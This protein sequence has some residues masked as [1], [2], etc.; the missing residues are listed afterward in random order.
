MIKRLLGSIKEYKK[1]S[2]LTPIFIII[3][4]AMEVLIP[5]LINWFGGCLQNGDGKGMLI[6]GLLMVLS[7][8]I[9]LM[10]GM[11]AG[12]TCAKAAT[13]FSKN[14]LYDCLFNAKSLKLIFFILQ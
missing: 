9:S 10:A 3:E 6:Y 2:I 1:E 8:G 12:K 7:A 5:L 11:I 13:G 4:V 14:F